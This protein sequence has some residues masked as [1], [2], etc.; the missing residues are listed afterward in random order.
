MISFCSCTK[1]N[2]YKVKDDILDISIHNGSIYI[3]KNENNIEDNI[4]DKNEMCNLFSFFN[5]FCWGSK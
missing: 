4:E 2:Q 3:K 1:S 5:I